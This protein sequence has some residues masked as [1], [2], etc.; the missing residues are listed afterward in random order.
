MS[1]ELEIMVSLKI[2]QYYPELMYMAI[3]DDDTEKW[4]AA[5]F[6]V[7]PDGSIGDMLYC[8][9]SYIYHSE[10]QAINYIKSAVELS[11]NAIRVMS[12]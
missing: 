4:D 9:D 2:A 10:H 6:S 12:N 8:F 7:L 3:Q 11:M 1:I 5:V